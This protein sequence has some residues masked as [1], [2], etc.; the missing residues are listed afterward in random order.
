MPTNNHQKKMQR[1]RE[2]ALDENENPERRLRAAKSLVE[3]S[4]YSQR[5]CPV[6]RRVANQLLT[7]DMPE[8]VR[9]LAVKLLE[10]VSIGEAR[11]LSAVRQQPVAPIEPIA[12]EVQRVLDG[13]D[14]P[15][16]MGLKMQESEKPA[17]PKPQRQSAGIKTFEQACAFIE[18]LAEFDFASPRGT[19]I[20]GKPWM[21]FQTRLMESV[22][23]ILIPHDLFAEIGGDW[24]EQQRYK[25]PAEK[26]KAAVVAFADRNVDPIKR[27]LQFRISDWRIVPIGTTKFE[28]GPEST[29]VE[30]IGSTNHAAIPTPEA[31]VVPET[32]TICTVCSGATE[33]FPAP[34]HCCELFQAPIT[35]GVKRI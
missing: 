20:A 9:T 2:R 16:P 12:D 32:R 27:G 31:P 29:Q 35:V 10:S 6:A 23:E 18:G 24:T 28:L 33:G 1:Y 5:S 25:W 17:A 3:L 14:A 15:L 7:P 30:S 21:N 22:G 26:M 11:R 13:E 34:E 4:D 8:S 19:E